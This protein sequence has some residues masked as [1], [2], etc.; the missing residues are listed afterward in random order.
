MN[1]DSLLS[2]L[3][4]LLVIF[5][6][7][8]IPEVWVLISLM[9]FSQWDSTALWVI[10]SGVGKLKSLNNFYPC[11]NTKQMSNCSLLVHKWGKIGAVHNM[12]DCSSDADCIGLVVK[13]KL[14]CKTLSSHMI[15][16]CGYW[17]NNMI[18]IVLANGTCQLRCLNLKCL[19]EPW[20]HSHY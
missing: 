20:H 19:F 14:R 4:I 8:F 15:E 12:A 17:Q 16:N 10:I 11:L 6:G 7:V 13:K 3:V 5:V 18:I 9:P 1:P 2:C